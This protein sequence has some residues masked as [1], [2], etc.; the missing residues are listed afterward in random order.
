MVALAIAKDRAHITA[1]GV[2]DA[3]ESSGIAETLLAA[4]MDTSQSSHGCDSVLLDGIMSKRIDE[5]KAFLSQNPPNFPFEMQ[6]LKTKT[7]MNI[8]TSVAS[9][10]DESW[11]LKGVM[12]IVSKALWAELGIW[13]D[14]A[15]LL[16]Q[17]VLVDTTVPKKCKEH[18]PD[19]EKLHRFMSLRGQ[20]LFRIVAALSAAF[21]VSKKHLADKNLQQ[22]LTITEQIVQ[23]HSADECL[24]SLAVFDMK[25][26]DR[27]RSFD[28][29]FNA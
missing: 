18:F 7:F 6:L 4:C 1:E 11:T 22:Q 16:A 24:K 23:S 14:I 8:H 19:F 5:L 9:L 3:V 25:L 15:P 17:S 27:A 29:W 20:T 10:S 26:L 28:E 12:T 13:C 2:S 21:N